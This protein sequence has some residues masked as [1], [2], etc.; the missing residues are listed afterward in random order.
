MVPVVT[1]FENS[2][3]TEGETL[4]AKADEVGLTVETTIKSETFTGDLAGI[5]GADAGSYTA[6]YSG[7]GTASARLSYSQAGIYNISPT[8]KM[9][10]VVSLPYAT[11]MPGEPVDDTAYGGEGGFYIYEYDSSTSTGVAYALTGC[12]NAVGMF[13]GLMTDHYSAL[14]PAN[15]GAP[16]MDN[17]ALLAYLQDDAG[18]VNTI[19]DSPVGKVLNNNPN[20]TEWYESHGNTLAYTTGDGNWT[21]ETDSAAACSILQKYNPYLGIGG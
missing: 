17:A 15:F 21:F 4:T 3:Y 5:N 11:H 2:T 14:N 9:M 8:I 20:F 7:E 13:Y 18:A 16:T 6:T 10:V 19:V 12:I 1:G